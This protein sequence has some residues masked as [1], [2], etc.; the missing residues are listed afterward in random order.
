MKTTAFLSLLPLA[1]AGPAA[2]KRAGGPAPLHTPRD[3]ASLVHGQYIVKM[4]DD[5]IFPMD[6]A[7]SLFPGDAIHS[8]HHQGFQGFA[9]KL[10]AA[11]LEAVQNHGGVSPR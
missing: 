11:A 8:W 6:S 9:A 3:A 4:K 7:M 1:F 5:T 2:Y 10:D